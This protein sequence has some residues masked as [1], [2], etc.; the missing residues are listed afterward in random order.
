MET[1]KRVTREA[2]ERRMLEGSSDWGG[3]RLFAR[4]QCSRYS[5]VSVGKHTMYV[6]LGTSGQPYSKKK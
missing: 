5:S 3:P 1:L 6:R 2:G 4:G